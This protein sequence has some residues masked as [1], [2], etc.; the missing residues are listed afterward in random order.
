MKGAD[1]FNFKFD[2]KYDTGDAKDFEFNCGINDSFGWRIGKTEIGYSFIA[3]PAEMGTWIMSLDSSCMINGDP[4]VNEETV[5]AKRRDATEPFILGS[6]KGY[7]LSLLASGIASY[8][9]IY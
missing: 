2:R 5:V 8:A 1:T 9:S 6:I 7:S 3:N 4:S